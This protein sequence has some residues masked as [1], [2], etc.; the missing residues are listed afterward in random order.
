MHNYENTLPGP[1]DYSHFP[2]GRSTVHVASH[3]DSC[4]FYFIELFQTILCSEVGRG[5]K[6]DKNC[7]TDLVRKNFE[8][9]HSSNRLVM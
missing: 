1:H 7:D 8:V 9:I 2:A 6:T 4:V 5:F 3:Y